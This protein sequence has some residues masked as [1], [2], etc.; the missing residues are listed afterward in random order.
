MKQITQKELFTHPRIA[1]LF[2]VLFMLL[3]IFIVG[4]PLLLFAY[5]VSLN[6]LL[7]LGAPSKLHR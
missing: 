6:A 4:S 7:S 5:P 1:I 3:R 2:C